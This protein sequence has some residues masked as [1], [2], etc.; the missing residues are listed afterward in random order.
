MTAMLPQLLGDMTLDNSYTVERFVREAAQGR[1][2]TI[3][4]LLPKM[5][6]RVSD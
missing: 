2:E 3:K 5:K 1:V 4:K 6:D